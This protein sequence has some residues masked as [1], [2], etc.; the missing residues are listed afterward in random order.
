MSV[1]NEVMEAVIGLINADSI[2]DFPPCTRG[3]LPTG[4]GLV[5]EPDP[6]IVQDLF[7]DKNTFVPLNVTINGKHPNLKTLSDVM[8]NIHSRL[9][10]RRVY[11]SGEGWQISDIKN[12]TLPRIIGREDNNDWIMASGLTVEFYWRGD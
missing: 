9:T 1:I 11:P 3:A 5:C 2:A 10:R 12:E 4:K 6:A 8:N 7:F